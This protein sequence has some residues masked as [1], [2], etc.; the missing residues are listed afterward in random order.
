VAFT[1]M[2]TCSAVGLARCWSSRLCPGVRVAE[3]GWWAP[4]PWGLRS[5]SCC[6]PVSVLTVLGHLTYPLGMALTAPS[7][8][9]CKESA[10]L[11]YRRWHWRGRD[12]GQDVDPAVQCLSS[13][14]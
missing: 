1:D 7:R 2:E 13:V 5:L 9:L 8:G 3:G 11:W 6:Q 12:P 10:A 4:Q 14:A